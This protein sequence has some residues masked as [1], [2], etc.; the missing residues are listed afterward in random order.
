MN[1]FS[2]AVHGIV[3]FCSN[4]VTGMYS[5]KNCNVFVDLAEKLKKALQSSNV[6]MFRKA[7]CEVLYVACL[8]MVSLNNAKL[9]TDELGNDLSDANAKGVLETLQVQ[10]EQYFGISNGKM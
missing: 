1:D 3:V 8:K 4:L 10:V 2:L 9:L 7:I 6:T 5:V